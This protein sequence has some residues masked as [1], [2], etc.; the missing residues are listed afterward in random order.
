MKVTLKT[1]WET[2]G[3][4]EQLAITDFNDET[5]SFRVGRIHDAA[6]GYIKS[7]R[8]SNDRLLRKY[9]KEQTIAETGKPAGTYYIPSGTEEEDRYNAEW[10]KLTSEEVQI[11]AEVD[12]SLFTLKQLHEA[13]GLVD[14]DEPEKGYK[15]LPLKPVYLGALARWLITDGE[16]EAKPKKKA[17]SE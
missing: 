12:Y 17:A 3:A 13:M 7:L 16:V 4:L 2:Y 9:G 14:P 8:K 15:R 6:M 5:I 11:L 1:L 10:D